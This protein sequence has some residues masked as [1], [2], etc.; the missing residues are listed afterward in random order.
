M[1]IWN[2]LSGRKEEI[3][4][5]EGRPLHLFVCG[6]TVYDY[7]H[8]G[9]ARTYVVFDTFVRYLRQKNWDV[10]YLQNVTNVD[11][12]IIARAKEQNKDP[13]KFA[14][15][16][17]K[18]YLEDM[19]TLG[20]ASVD[21]YAPAS[22]FIPQIV[23][24][25]VTLREKGF[26]YEIGGDGIYFDIAKFPDYGKLSGRTAAQ[27]EDGISRIDESV[28]KRNRGDFALWKFPKQAAKPNLFQNIRG[29]FIDSDGEPTW[30]TSLGWGRPGWHIEDTAISESFFG[31]Q[32]DIHGAALDLKFPHHEAEIAQQESASGRKPFVRVWMHAGFLT[33]GGQKMSKS[34]GNFV[35]IRD[36][37][38]IHSASI[39]RWFFLSHHYRTPM[40]YSVENI[41][42][43]K[44][45]YGRMKV[46][47]EKL[48]FVVKTNRASSD[49]ADIQK[50]IG[51]FSESFDKAMNDDF[52]TPVALASVLTLASD[53][54]EKVWN[55]S[56]EEAKAVKKSLEESLDVMGIT[57]QTEAV[58][59]SMRKMAAERELCRAN[60]QFIQSDA[61]RKEIGMLGY[62]IEDTPQGPFVYKE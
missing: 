52:N 27:A 37:L 6:M 41:E 2:T 24:Q 20:V 7:T 61:L 51:G 17:T 10:F 49:N 46:F 60:K 36:V 34:L 38:K 28:D 25:V 11:D 26:A 48:E 1:K 57:I 23:K 53:L 19:R 35:T 3:L 14:D 9:H 39:L 43:I 50:K 45:I 31:P 21:K 56:S 18:A 54:Q 13:L 8:I 22:E 55:L 42:Q 29:F 62:S 15:F 12:K 58:P 4:K 40:D 44:T 5:P 33:I 30:K 16:F 59:D 32:Y 47:F